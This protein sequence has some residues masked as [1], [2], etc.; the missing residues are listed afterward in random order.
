MPMFHTIVCQ[1]CGRGPMREDGAVALFAAGGQRYCAEHLPIA[2]VRRRLELAI[3][4]VL[5]PELRGALER[6]S[7]RR[8][9]H[10]RRPAR[11]GPPAATYP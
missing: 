9:R 8:P 2:E 7:P 5:D 1:L 10:E 3:G 6:G 4:P 11:H